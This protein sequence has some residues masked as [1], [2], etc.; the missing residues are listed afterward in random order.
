MKKNLLLLLMGLL[1]LVA[2]AIPADPAPAQITQ[3]DG[4]VLTLKLHG[5][6]FFHFTTT[7]DGYTVMKNK[8]GYY[9]YARLE[10]N[11][12]VAGDRIARNAEART[13]ADR[14]L[15]ANT[16]K[17]LTDDNARQNGMRRLGQRNSNKRPV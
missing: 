15:L 8:A 4:T 6:E 3:P 10:G 7:S 13:A 5:D 17:Y 2:R 9:T 16:P 11:R 14:T 12:L 1:C